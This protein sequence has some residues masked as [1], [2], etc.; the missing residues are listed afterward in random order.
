MIHRGSSPNYLT[1]CLSPKEQPHMCNRYIPPHGDV[2]WEEVRATAPANLPTG[3]IFPRRP[4]VYV[5]ADSEVGRQ[6]VVGQ[7][8]LIP[9]FAK[10]LPLKFSTNNA[11]AESAPT[12]ATFKP[13]WFR[14]Q[15]C[16]IPADSFDEPN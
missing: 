16:I 8:G 4:G 15:R 13:S 2:L 6:A 14:G 1:W 11:R 7:W 5:R 9:W 10:S 3:P 12:A